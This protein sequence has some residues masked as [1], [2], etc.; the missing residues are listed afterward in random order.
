MG[1]QFLDDA[2]DDDMDLLAEEE[3][4]QP[5]EAAAPPGE[6]LSP[7]T[8][9]QWLEEARQ[10]YEALEN[11][12]RELQIMIDRGRT[13]VERL[14]QHSATLLTYVRQQ[15]A[16]GKP[17][18]AAREMQAALEAQQRFLMLRGQIE[19]ME[20][21]K[22]RLEELK[23]LLERH[24]TVLEHLLNLLGQAAGEEETG[25]A[26]KELVRMILETEQNVRRRVARQMHDGPAQTLSN[27]ILQAE[28][29][30][31]VYARAPK[32]LPDELRTL[33]D[34]AQKSFKAVRLFITQLRPMALDDLGLTPTL[35][36]YLNTLKQERG[37][38]T[39]LRVTGQPRR[40]DTLLEMLAFRAV[41]EALFEA[42]HSG[43]P[44]K[45]TVLVDFQDPRQLF[46][47]MSLEG[48]GLDGLPDTPQTEE[49][50]L[51]QEQVS[52]LGGSFRIQPQPGKGRV[53]EV[54][55]PERMAE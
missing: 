25:V 6:V 54:T 9:Q 47:R 20:A 21:D 36:R 14:G 53:I 1:L 24:I 30:Q 33:E 42:E 27:L 29:V 44:H 40:M 31:R 55:I 41:Q 35:Q 50:R 43:Q 15:L 23:D 28:I 49:M 8:V 11:Q 5:A 34:M 46:L 39:D 2:L 51:L 16:R 45:L 3:G 18:E 37:L 4:G 32:Q 10:R 48:M 12:L 38:E 26:S 22:A 19:K 7:A 13:E 17:A 52:L